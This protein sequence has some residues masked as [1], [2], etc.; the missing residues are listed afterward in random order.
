M[1]AFVHRRL[2]TETKILLGIFAL[3]SLVYALSSIGYELQFGFWPSQILS[4]F[5][6][7]ELLLEPPMR[8][9]ELIFHLHFRL[10]LEIIVLLLLFGLLAA[11]GIGRSLII[12]FL[13]LCFGVLLEIGVSLLLR[14]QLVFAWAFLKQAL[15]LLTRLLMVYLSLDA[16]RRLK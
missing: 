11:V 15:F 12:V 7:S 14:W 3:I 6:G 8:W 9:N 5:A 16:L 13:V 1:K 10:F 4:Y 2:T